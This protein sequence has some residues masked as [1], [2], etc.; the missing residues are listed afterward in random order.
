MFFCGRSGQRLEPVRVVR[1]HGPFLHGVGHVGGDLHVQRRAGLDGGEQLAA[2]VLR[3]VLA[4]GGGVEDV[5]RVIVIGFDGGCG[6]GFHCGELCDCV[7]RVDPVQIAHTVQLLGLLRLSVALKHIPCQLCFRQIP[8]SGFTQN[9]N[10]P[11]DFTFSV[12]KMRLPDIETVC[13]FGRNRGHIIIIYPSFTGFPVAQPPF[14]R[15]SFR[16][17][18]FPAFLA[19]DMLQSKL[20][21]CR[22]H[23]QSS[24]SPIG[25]RSNRELTFCSREA[26]SGCGDTDLTAPLFSVFLGGAV[27][28]NF[29]FNVPGID[30]FG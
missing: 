1:G 18:G 21:R 15:L 3:Q 27:F 10:F 8:D 23:S 4:H 11:V 22:P 12:N 19:R 5:F 20:V 6:R 16:P 29:L 9:V 25:K 14:F 7:D 17:R 30:F 13:F 2:D 24:V 28:F 26:H